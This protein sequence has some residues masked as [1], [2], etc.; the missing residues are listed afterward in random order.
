[1]DLEVLKFVGAGLMT[2]G[3]LGAAVGI[4]LIFGKAAEGIA[5][6]PSAEAKIFKVAIFG[7]VL[8]ELMG[9]FAFVGMML[10][11]FVL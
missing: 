6:N 1:M 10:L 4:G 5:R 9:L 3:M 8:A 2:F 7:A 11:F